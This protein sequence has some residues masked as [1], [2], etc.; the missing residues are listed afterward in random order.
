M[1]WL[2]VAVAF[3][4]FALLGGYALVRAVRE[5]CIGFWFVPEE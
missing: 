2:I 4:P 1:T 5:F 3:L